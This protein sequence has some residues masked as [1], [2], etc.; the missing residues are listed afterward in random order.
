[1]PLCHARLAPAGG[2]TLSHLIVK[3]GLSLR[4]MSGRSP[5]QPPRGQHCLPRGTAVWE[6]PVAFA[7]EQV[8]PRRS[9]EVG[10]VGE[11]HVLAVVSVVWT[12]TGFNSSFSTY[13]LCLNRSPSLPKHPFLPSVK[14]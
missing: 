3:P 4:L 9:L 5:R 12:D 13:S 7:V 6:V 1:M 11:W 10:S 14:E 2:Q 8:V